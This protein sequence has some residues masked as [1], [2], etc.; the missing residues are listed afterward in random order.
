VRTRALAAVLACALCACGDDLTSDIMPHAMPPSLT[1]RGLV[2][3]EATEAFVDVLRSGLA[4]QAIT[5]LRLEGDEGF[6]LARVE[7]GGG[8]RPL[9]LARVHVR[10]RAPDA[11]PRGAVLRLRGSGRRD[12]YLDVR[13]AFTPP[14]ARI[15]VSDCVASVLRG[16]GGVI[17]IGPTDDLLL[18]FGEVR[19]GDC[20]TGILIVENTGD[21][22]LKVEGR[23]QPGSAQE[24][25]LDPALLAPFELS[26]GAGRRFEIEHCETAS[27]RSHAQVVLTTN[28][29]ERPQ[30]T[31]NLAGSIH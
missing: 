20:R 7:P 15:E 17:C 24:F 5:S 12:W 31:V 27:L 1:F 25:T 2:P 9:L 16:D 28:D 13:L 26:G 14:R 10:F 11:R 18:D 22:V 19:A 29:P 23:L 30:V 21:S 4:S 3:G 6:T 8:D